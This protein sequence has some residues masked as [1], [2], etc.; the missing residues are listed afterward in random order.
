MKEMFRRKSNTSLLP[1]NSSPS[2]KA[3]LEVGK[4]VGRFYHTRVEDDQGEEPD[5]IVIG[6]SEGLDISLLLPNINCHE[7]FL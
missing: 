7:G 4:K 2:F 3:R 5:I 6:R 1:P